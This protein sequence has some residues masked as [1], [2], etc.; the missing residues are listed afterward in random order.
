MQCF[1]YVRDNKDKSLYEQFNKCADYAK[2]YGYSVGGRV[3][4]F[5]GT[6]FHSAVNKIIADEKLT[7][8]I[9]YSKETAF[10]NYSD[11]LFY[12]IY[13]DKLGKQLLSCN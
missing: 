6:Q 3:L 10:E 7:T 4:D 5:D 1:I 13:F 8:L 2:R 9:I 11:Y 12:Q